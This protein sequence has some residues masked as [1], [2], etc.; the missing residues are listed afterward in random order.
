MVRE[1]GI[2]GRRMARLLGYDRDFVHKLKK[3]IRRELLAGLDKELISKDIAELE[4]IYRS[5]AIDMYEII[6]SNSKDRDKIK[7][8]GLLLDAKSRLIR[9]KMT[10]GIYKR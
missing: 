7:A 1:P 8:V 5:M 4:N 3:R 9:L 6:T 10:F 2:S